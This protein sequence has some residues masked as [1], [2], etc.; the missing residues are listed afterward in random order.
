MDLAAET[1]LGVVR[2]F[3]IEQQTPALVRFV[4]FTAGACGAFSRVLETMTG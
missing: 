3:V 4:L 2:T 1:S